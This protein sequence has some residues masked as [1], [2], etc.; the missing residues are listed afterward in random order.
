[1]PRLQ[2]W[3]G[4]AHCRYAYSGLQLP[5]L[6]WTPALL[7]LRARV[8]GLAGRPFNSVLL[9]YYRDGRDSVSWHS[10]DEKELGPDPVVASLSLGAPR[11]FQMK[12][13][14]RGDLPRPAWELGHGSLLLMGR[15]SQT[16]WRHQLP[17]QPGVKEARVN[18]TF[19]SIVG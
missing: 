4:E 11:R 7:E 10:D 13:R 14:S 3:F 6:P 5:P 17:K 19:R 18:L 15:G 9:N 1:M 16:G 12:H 2:A 8:E